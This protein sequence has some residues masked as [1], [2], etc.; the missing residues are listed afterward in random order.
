M[1]H[2]QHHDRLESNVISGPL[3]AQKR[4]MICGSWMVVAGRALLSLSREFQERS[5]KLGT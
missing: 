3:G 4:L 1:K 5:F 2:F